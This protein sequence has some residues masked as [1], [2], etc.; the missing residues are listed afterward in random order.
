MHAKAVAG[1]VLLVV[2][3]LL[4]GSSP[5]AFRA[6]PAGGYPMSSPTEAVGASPT[7]DANPRDRACETAPGS[8]AC[9]VSA[10][11]VD[12]RQ[13]LAFIQ[14]PSPNAAVNEPLE[15]QPIVAIRDADGAAGTTD[16]TRVVTLARA[17]GPAEG[18]LTCANELSRP[19]VKGYAVFAGCKFDTPGSF[20]IRASV[21]ELDPIESS[22]VTLPRD[23][24]DDRIDDVVDATRLPG[25]RDSDRVVYSQAAVPSFA[26]AANPERSD[27]GSDF[28]VVIDGR[29][30]QRLP[31][32]VPAHPGNYESRKANS[33]IDSIVIHYCGR[34]GDLVR[35]CIDEFTALK[36]KA[37]H[38]VVSRDGLIVQMVDTTYLAY[39]ARYYNNRSIGIE[40]A[41]TG[42]ATDFTEAMYQSLAFLVARLS[43]E[44]GIP[45]VHPEA[46]ATKVACLDVSGVIGHDQIQPPGL[47]DRALT[48]TKNRDIA[49]NQRENWGTCADGH[50]NVREVALR[51]D[52]GPAFDWQKLM[53]L[54]RS[55]KRLLA[56]PSGG[57]PVVAVEGAHHRP[58]VVRAD[59]GGAAPE[60]RALVIACGDVHFLRA[61][62]SIQPACGSA[63][64][65]S[66]RVGSVAPSSGAAAI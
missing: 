65:R 15:A 23:S 21:P 48:E 38:Y 26:F 18:V 1:G 50:D 44:H 8:R 11:E 32:L 35:D 28:G 22:S 43:I 63:P 41:S 3:L 57:L 9:A 13:R 52:P 27:G 19:V 14:Q 5:N 45:L 25:L 53:G 60:L 61:G 64:P 6:T 30:L 40:L 24:D 51:D 55:A 49:P 36:E 17:S 47:Y 58:A 12:R 42:A 31:L 16:D 54:A 59:G 2:L 7:A 56:D 4:P 37:A 10:V 46:R 20:T 66:G 33:V 39:H 29:F 62:E 34:G